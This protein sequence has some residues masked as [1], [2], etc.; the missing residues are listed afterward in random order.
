MT[1]CLK[2]VKYNVSNKYKN[3]LEFDSKLNKYGRCAK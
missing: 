2:E 1:K 3:N